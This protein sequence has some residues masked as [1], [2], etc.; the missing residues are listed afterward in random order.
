MKRSR[1]LGAIIHALRETH[2]GVQMSDTEYFYIA[3]MILDE[4]KKEK[5]RGNNGKA[6]EQN[7]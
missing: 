6:Q 2:F 3:S 1:K 5:K 7:R 4:L